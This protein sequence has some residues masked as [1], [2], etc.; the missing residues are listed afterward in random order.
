MDKLAEIMAHKRLEIEHRIRPVRDTELNRLARNHTG[1]TF[2]EALS[3]PKGLAVIAE[4]KR[5]SPSAGKIAELPDATEQ[6]RKYHNAEVDCLSVLTDEKFFGGSLNDLCGVTDFLSDHRRDI[7]CL[8]KD[9]FIHPI[10]IVEAA[11]AGAKAMLIIVRALKDDE[12]DRLYDAA[13]AAGLDALFE[14]HTERELDRALEF[15]PKIVGVNNRDL[16]RFVTDIGISEKII[17][18]MPDDVIPVSES[19]IFTGEDAARARACGAKA[20]LCGEALMRQEDPAEL[21]EEFHNV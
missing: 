20:I 8:R 17:P 2:A 7:P 14:V 13:Q 9:F 21:V 19:G 4:I 11:E 15:S 10:Q 3:A 18:Q 5:R 12:I 6:A 16:S 1:K